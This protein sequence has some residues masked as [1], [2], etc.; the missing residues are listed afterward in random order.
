MAHENDPS[1]LMN[2]HEINAQIP[3]KVRF[4]GSTIG[5]LSFGLAVLLCGLAVLAW[6]SLDTAKKLHIQSTLLQDGRLVNGTIT[7]SFVNRGGTDVK[8]RFI[9][10]NVLYSGHAEM[11]ADDYSVPGDPHLISIRYLPADPRVNQPVNWKWASVWDLFPFLLLISM[12]AVGAKAVIIAQKMSNLVRNGLV[13]VGRVTGCTPKNKLFTVFYVFESQAKEEI[14]GSSDLQEEYEA[15]T[16][17]PV[18]Y[19]RSNPKRNAKY[20]VSGFRTIQ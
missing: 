16:A 7:A 8:Y 5:A 20:P 1:R 12:T 13:V 6:L 4:D 14:E 19:L 18:I 15:G 2:V 10:D 3:R 11:S 9:V 17:I